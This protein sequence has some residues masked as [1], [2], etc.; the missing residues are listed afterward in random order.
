MQLA[1]TVLIWTLIVG[2]A[3]GVVVFAFLSYKLFKD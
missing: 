3:V 1:G 2:V